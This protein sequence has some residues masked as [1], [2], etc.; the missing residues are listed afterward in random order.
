MNRF[1]FVLVVFLV[2]ESQIRPDRE[3]KRLRA[4]WRMFEPRW[5]TR[6]RLAVRRE[7]KRHAALDSAEVAGRKSAFPHPSG[8]EP[9][10]RRRC[11]LP[12]HC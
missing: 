2:L 11:A 4:T 3:Q 12:A 10:R 8:G 9:M 5:P 7:A 6:Q 1:V